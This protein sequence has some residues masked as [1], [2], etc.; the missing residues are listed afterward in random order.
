MTLA[1]KN[2]QLAQTISVSGNAIGDTV[3]IPSSGLVNVSGVLNLNGIPVSVSGHSHLSSD[4]SDFDSSV[5]GLLPTISNSENNRL[6]TST[7]SSVGINA[8]NNLTFN[9]S[10]LDVTGSGNFA[11]GLAINNQTVNTIA[12]FDGSKNVVSLNTSTYPNLT[13]LSYVKGVSSSIQTQLNGKANTS[14]T[15]TA[16]NITDFNSS[17]SGLLPVTGIVG[18][19][20]ITVTNTNRNFT[21]SSNGLQ[22]A[23]NYS[24]VGHSHIL[25]DISDAGSLA[26][27]NSDDVNITGG[28]INDVSAENIN[29]LNDKLSLTKNKIKKY[30]YFLTINTSGNVGTYNLLSEDDNDILT[31][32]DNQILTEYYG[33]Q[34]LFIPSGSL[35]QYCLNW[36][37]FNIT[38]DLTACF[39]MRGSIKHNSSGVYFVGSQIKEAYKD[40]GMSSVDI[41][42]SPVNSSLEIGTVSLSDKQY[43]WGGVLNIVEYSL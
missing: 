25:N 38:D 33:S 12:S 37:V 32:N 24:V 4:I 29:I 10:L 2:A 8:E 39:N 5:S 14:H 18:S 34:R 23:G 27:Q 19:Q 28:T 7:G 40:S 6:L 21:I 3:F 16:S 22:P 13:E 15:H 31:Q 26:S 41:V 17:V 35:W 42:I 20:Y 11:S 43:S 1:R 36:N 9:G 30:N